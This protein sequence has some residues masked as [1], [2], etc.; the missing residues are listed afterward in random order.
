MLTEFQAKDSIPDSPEVLGQRLQQSVFIRGGGAFL[1]GPDGGPGHG[2]RF[3][4]VDAVGLLHQLLDVLLAGAVR[5]EWS[6]AVD[7]AVAQEAVEAEV[8]AVDGV[9]PED[10]F[11]PHSSDFFL[12]L[13]EVRPVQFLVLGKRS[14]LN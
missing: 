5:L 11:E 1:R 10:P 12:E 14:T 13:V 2:R 4:P 7:P 3:E 8:A 6:G 9:R